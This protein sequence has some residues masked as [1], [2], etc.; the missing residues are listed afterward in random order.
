MK[1][2]AITY[3]GVPY[4]MGNTDLAVIKSR[5]LDSA[6]TGTPFWLTVNSGEG[7]Y[8]ETDLLIAPGVPVAITGIDA[9]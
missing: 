3:G 5:L 8:Q 7:S 6:T 1:R 2:I 9:D 4:S